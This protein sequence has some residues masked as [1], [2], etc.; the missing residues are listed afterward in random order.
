MG[1]QI[2]NAGINRVKIR[3]IGARHMAPVSKALQHVP[4]EGILWVISV[5]QYPTKR[6]TLAQK[7]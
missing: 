1:K 5:G 4:Q 6:V 7:R 3:D 2:A